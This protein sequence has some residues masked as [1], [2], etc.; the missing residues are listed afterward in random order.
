MSFHNNRTPGEMIERVD[1]DI[2]ALGNFFSQFV[3]Q[4]LGNM[5]LMAGVLVLLFMEDW[6]AG[7]G[8]SIFAAVSMGVALSLRQI[9]VPH[10]KANSEASSE[11][12]GFLARKIHK[13]GSFPIQVIVLY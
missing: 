3:I 11:M 2:N 5:L 7:S 12:F 1:G 9:A 8:L 6:R 4:M 13:K 10:M